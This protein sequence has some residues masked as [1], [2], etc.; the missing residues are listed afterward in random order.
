[1]SFNL[2]PIPTYPTYPPY[3]TGKYIEDFF[4]GWLAANEIN[5]KRQYI[6][7]SWTTLYCENIG[8]IQE[9]LSTL[10]PMG[11]YFT[12]CQHDDAPREDLPYDTKIFSCSQAKRNYRNLDLV[13]I[14]AVCSRIPHVRKA[15]IDIFASFVG[16]ITH[17]I[18]Q[19]LYSVCQD[20]FYFSSSQWTPSVSQDRLNEFINITSRSRFTLCP[21]GYGNTSFRMYEA[22][23][24]GSVP[25]YISDQFWLPWQDELNWGDFCV[26]VNDSEI[27][28]LPEILSDISNTKYQ[29]MLD[30]AKDFYPYY[31]TL[32]GVCENIKR[33][34]ESEELAL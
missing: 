25:V 18:R 9:Y 1:M 16:S 8:G 31:F 14:P 6:P 29:D 24:L 7:I 20:R 32:K 15:D 26:V 13:P 19:K 21:R 2:R 27:A 4:Y 3:H 12:I 10:D 5:T 22:M 23:Q 34:L 11:S 17:P 33:V 28:N 30:F